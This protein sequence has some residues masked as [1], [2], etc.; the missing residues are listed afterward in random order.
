MMADTTDRQAYMRRVLATTAFVVSILLIVWLLL[1]VL[2][3]VPFV[4]SLPGTSELRVHAGATVAC[5]LVAAWG[6]WKR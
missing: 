6:F 2:H 5:L 1:G 4:L 3:I